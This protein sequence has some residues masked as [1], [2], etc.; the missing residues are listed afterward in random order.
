[1]TDQVKVLQRQ[2]REERSLH[3][4][5]VKQ[6]NTIMTRIERKL[7]RVEKQSAA[8]AA[9]LR[10]GHKKKTHRSAMKRGRK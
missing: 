5:F 7:V 9:R 2:L 4:A 6:A 8:L 1:M 3:A 10:D